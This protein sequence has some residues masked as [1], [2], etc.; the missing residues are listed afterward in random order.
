MRNLI[1]IVGICGI[2][3]LSKAQFRTHIQ[4]S[5][6]TETQSIGISGA[7]LFG[8][9]YQFLPGLQG[10][11]EYSR[12]STTRSQNLSIPIQFIART[13]FFGRHSC[14][15]GAFVELNGGAKRNIPLDEVRGN[16]EQ[17]WTPTTDL[18]VGYRTGM[19]H[20]FSLYYG[21]TF[22]NS[23]MNKMIGLRYGF[24]L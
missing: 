12:Q 7:Y 8:L 15:G 20:E 14:C 11:I 3:S 22:E 18:S 21:G 16:S 4:N 6:V 10:G 5:S 19:S 13:Y 24:N 1:L 9:T 23:K 17:K 2:S